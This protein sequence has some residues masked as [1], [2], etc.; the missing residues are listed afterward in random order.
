MSLELDLPQNIIAVT[1][2]IVGWTIVLCW[3][4]LRYRK[5]QEKP[6]IWKMILA[7]LVGILSISIHVSVFSTAVKLSVVPIGVLLVFLFMRN[8]TWST[9]RRF[10]WIG[11]FSSYI[12]V[13]TT[14]LGSWLH[15][16]VYDKTDPA[17]YLADIQQVQVIGIHPSAGHIGWDQAMFEKRL[18]DLLLEQSYNTLDWYYESRPAGETMH[19]SEK[20]PYALLGAKPSWGSGYESAVFLESDGK[21]LLIQTAERHYYFRSEEPLV[22]LEVTAHED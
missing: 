11:F 15:Q 17:T 5:L 3:I 19:A 12:L 8:G 9:Y 22:K 20:F 10:A 4:I 6:A 16:T 18:P 1:A 2:S 21:G 14:L 13:A 7:A